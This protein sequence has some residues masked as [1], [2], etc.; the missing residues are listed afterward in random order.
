MM[1]LWSYHMFYMHLKVQFKQNFIC[2]RRVK[3]R[4]AHTVSDKK[5]FIL[6]KWNMIRLDLLTAFHLWK[7]NLSKWK[8]KKNSYLFS[9]GEG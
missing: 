8:Q 3:R 4:L 9:W 6:I 1:K 5:H 2:F 7:T